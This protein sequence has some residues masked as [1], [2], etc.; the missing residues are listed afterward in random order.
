[1]NSTLRV[2][3]LA[4]VLVLAGIGPGCRAANNGLDGSAD[5]RDGGGSGS[6]AGGHGGFGDP[7]TTTADCNSGLGCIGGA[8]LSDPTHD[9]GAGSGDSGGGGG[10]GG[11]GRPDTD[12][13]PPPGMEG[14]GDACNADTMR[15]RFGLTCRRGVCEG[16]NDAPAGAPCELSGTCADGL[17]CAEGVCTTAGTGGVGDPCSGDSGCEATLRCVSGMCSPTGTDDIGDTCLI[18]TECSAGLSC[19]GGTCQA[20]SPMTATGCEADVDAV[21][22]TCATAQPTSPRLCVYD[23]IRPLCGTGRASFIRA[24]FSCLAAS[25]PCATPVDPSS[26]DAI[27]CVRSTVVSHLTDTD[28]VLG[29]TACDCDDSQDGCEYD[30]PYTTLATAM[31]M[32]LT[33]VAN[34]EECVDA[35]CDELNN[36]INASP[37]SG[38]FACF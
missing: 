10:D 20:S 32:G 5:G 7:C 15:C 27:A 31:M 37:L 29:E 34:L 26:E 21:R 38:V 22:A 13:G 17:Y 11:G 14:V 6:D 33:D 8:C 16:S 24:M 1:M 2:T 35:D 30:I 18:P 23:A 36:C 3:T 19:V 12:A 25:V 4:S 28:W 9:A